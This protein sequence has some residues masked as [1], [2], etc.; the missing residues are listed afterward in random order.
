M[1]AKPR[2]EN[3]FSINGRAD[4]C[5]KFT[6][7]AKQNGHTA[8]DVAAWQDWQWEAAAAL[9]G[10]KVPSE[11]GRGQIIGYLTPNPFWTPARMARDVEA[12][13]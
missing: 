7:W 8:E 9:A 12:A 4:Y 5:W 6:R 11:R 10:T 2:E 1:A 3:R 13:G